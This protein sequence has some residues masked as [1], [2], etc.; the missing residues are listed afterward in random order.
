MTMCVVLLVYIQYSGQGVVKCDAMWNNGVVHVENGGVLWCKMWNVVVEYGDVEWFDAI[1][2]M[3]VWCWMFEMQCGMCGVVWNVCCGIVW[4]AIYIWMWWCVWRGVRWNV[5][6]MWWYDLMWIMVRCEMWCVWCDV[7]CRNFR[8]GVL[9]M[10]NVW[11][12]IWCGVECIVLVRGMLHNA[13]MWKVTWCEMWWCGI[14]V[15]KNVA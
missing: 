11:C 10:Q 12:G 14:V 5:A 7:E 3:A 13:K 15:M 6:E 4:C 2:D 1:L 9:K 8:H